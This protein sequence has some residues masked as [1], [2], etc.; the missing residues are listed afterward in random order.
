MKSNGLNLNLVDQFGFKYNKKRENRWVCQ[1]KS[2]GC[3]VIIKTDGDFIVAQKS[4]HTCI[5]PW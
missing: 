2:K 1:K 4:D 3:K 5:V